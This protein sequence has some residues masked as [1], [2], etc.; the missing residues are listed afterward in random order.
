MELTPKTPEELTEIARGIVTNR[1]YAAWSA[2]ALDASFGMYL[3]MIAGSLQEQGEDISWLNDV[4]LIYEDSEKA[5]ERGL[6]GYPTFFSAKFLHR[7]DRIPLN[8]ECIRLAIALG[9][10]PED[11]LTDFDTAVA[12]HAAAEVKPETDESTEEESHD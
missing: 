6:N 2:E 8:R 4:G 12:S 10:L 11:A 5:N 9:E 1:V 3:M 7:D